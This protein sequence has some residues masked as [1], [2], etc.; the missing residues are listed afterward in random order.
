MAAHRIPVHYDAPRTPMRHASWFIQLLMLLAVLIL[1]GVVYGFWGISQA[2]GPRL[3]VPDAA[4]P[5]TPPPP[6]SP[7]TP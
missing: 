1:A 7:Q 4:Q 3:E 2:P 5:Q 6:A